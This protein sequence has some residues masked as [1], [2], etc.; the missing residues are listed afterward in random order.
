[1]ALEQVCRPTLPIA[2]ELI[3]LIHALAMT[4]KQFT[5]AGR[6]TCA[7]IKQRDTCFPTGERLIYHRQI[8]DDQRKKAKAD[9]ALD[10]CQ[11]S[12]ER[13]E[14]SDVTEAHRKERRPAKVNV[15]GKS[16]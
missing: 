16:R 7:R 5:C 9:T 10:D 3:Q 4:T 15:C 6:R 14:R 1:M 11:S 2:Q 13:P 12:P 8:T